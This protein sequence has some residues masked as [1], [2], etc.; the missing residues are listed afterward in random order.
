MKLQTK[1]SQFIAKKWPIAPYHLYKILIIAG[2]GSEIALYNFMNHQPGI[3]KVCLYT[4]D[5]YEKRY[6]L[7]IKELEDGGR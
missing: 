3:D 1:I 7:L 4:K 6:K 2:S 5:L